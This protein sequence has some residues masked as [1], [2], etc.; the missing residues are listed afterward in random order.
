MA[1][2]TPADPGGTDGLNE[3]T[4]RPLGQA[5]SLGGDAGRLAEYYSAWADSYDADVGGDGYGLPRSVMVTLDAAADHE[6]W[7]LDTSITVL[8]AGCGTGRIGVE[9]AARGYTALDGVDLS[10]E[11]VAIAEARGIYRRLEAGVDLT[12]Q[13]STTWERK[14]DLVVIGGVFTVG[15]IPP[16]SIH[17]VAKLVRPGG[18]LIVTVRPGYYDTTDFGEV[19]ADFAD[20]TTADL[21]VHFPELPYTEDSHGLYYAYR[22]H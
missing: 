1:N 22:V 21:I 6:P 19:S 7:L 2:S 17:E 14:A 15:H 12:R 9:L 5:M 13:P 4:A 3:R 18:V 10:P 8:D 20:G 11:M 16:R